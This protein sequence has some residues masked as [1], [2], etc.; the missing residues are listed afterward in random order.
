M[1]IQLVIAVIVICLLALVGAVFN[2]SDKINELTGGVIDLP[3]SIQ[4]EAS[5]VNIVPAI[6]FLAVL[7]VAYCAFHS[8]R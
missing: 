7:L 6:V 2:S 3:V 4:G 5:L 8:S 1:R